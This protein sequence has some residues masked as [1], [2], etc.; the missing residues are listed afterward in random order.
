MC[1][2]P[3]QWL[4]EYYHDYVRFSTETPYS[5]EKDTVRE[6]LERRSTD[7]W[8]QGYHS[9]TNGSVKGV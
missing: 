5:R 6:S 3:H 9:L 7:E 1:S 8:K 2:S 4:P